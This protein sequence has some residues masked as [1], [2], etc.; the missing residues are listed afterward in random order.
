[1]GNTWVTYLVRLCSCWMRHAS[2]HVTALL[3]CVG[4]GAYNV[5]QPT[6]CVCVCVCVCALLCAVNQNVVG[7]HVAA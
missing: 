4:H 2:L 5:K 6:V 3:T 1:M 7:C